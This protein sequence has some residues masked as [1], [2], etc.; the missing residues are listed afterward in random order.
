MIRKKAASARFSCFFF[1]VDI[2]DVVVVVKQRSENRVFL[3][4]DSK[5][6]Q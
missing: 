3:I 1:I 2:V 6:Q 5:K 4:C